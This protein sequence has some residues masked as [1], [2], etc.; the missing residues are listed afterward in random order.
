AAGGSGRNWL[1]FGEQHFVTDFLYQTE[2]QNWL[3]TGTLQK[4]SLAFSRD[5]QYKIYVQHRILEEGRELWKWIEKGAYIYLCG[6]RDPMSTDVEYALLQVI[7]RFGGRGSRD[8]INY[9]EDLKAAGRF[10][11]DVY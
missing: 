2:I 11:K 9:L 5:Q 4:L 8:A 6:T 10:L 7:E 1:F 3:Q